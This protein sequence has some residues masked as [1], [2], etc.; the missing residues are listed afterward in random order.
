[1]EILE[2]QHEHE[3]A[4]EEEDGDSKHNNN[5]IMKNIRNGQ[6]NSRSI[7]RLYLHIESARQNN[8]LS[9]K[10]VDFEKSPEQFGDRL[11]PKM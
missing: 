6:G 4:V 11:W 3:F 2:Q 10:H 5:D 9:S 7:C 1:M 8:S